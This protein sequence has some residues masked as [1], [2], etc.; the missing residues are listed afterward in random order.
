[1]EMPKLQATTRELQGRKNYILRNEGRVPG[2]VYGAGTTPLN[3]AVDHNTLAK[4]F[5]TAGESTLVEMQIEGGKT[6]NVLIQDIQ[7]DPLREDIIHADFRAV[8]MNKPIEAEVKLKF[9]GEAP[10]VKVLGGTL[11]RPME[12]L[13]IRALPKDLMSVIEIDLSKLVTFDDAVRVSELVL[14]EGVEVL[15]EPNSTL[16]LVAPPRSDEE[17]ASLDKAVEADV[18]AVKVEGEKKEGEEGAEVSTTEG[19]KKDE[20]AKTE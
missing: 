1:M 12:S 9:I 16:A 7:K 6:L 5:R 20:P 15:E 17:M 2:V 14:P 18:S 3:I 13:L 8:D 19:E 11:V 4:L 10:A